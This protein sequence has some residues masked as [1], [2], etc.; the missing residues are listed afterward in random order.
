MIFMAIGYLLYDYLLGKISVHFK[1]IR[2]VTRIKGFILH[3]MS[4]CCK[5]IKRGREYVLK[6]YTDAPYELVLSS[7]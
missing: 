7:A 5:W 1:E 4:V 6:L 2:R 3:F